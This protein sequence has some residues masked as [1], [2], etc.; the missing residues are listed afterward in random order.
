MASNRELSEQARALSEKLGVQVETQGLNN[1]ALAELVSSLNEKLASAEAAAP[2]QE[3]AEPVYHMA[4]NCQLYTLRGCLS[5]G[6]RVYVTDL[7]D[8][9]QQLDGL[10]SRGTVVKS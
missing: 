7:S 3:Q 8:G 9:Q 2:E 6:D 10:V 5:Y 4:K 1:Q